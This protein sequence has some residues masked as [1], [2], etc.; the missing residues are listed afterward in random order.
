MSV[1]TF[2][3]IPWS[4][5]TD[6]L[7]SKPL[8]KILHQLIQ[9]IERIF[10]TVSTKT[11]KILS[12]IM[13]WSAE[14]IK[15]PFARNGRHLKLEISELITALV[16]FASSKNIKK[17][18]KI[19]EMIANKLLD[20]PKRNSIWYLRILTSIAIVVLQLNLNSVKKL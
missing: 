14:L 12:I 15:A 20:K 7:N 9:L 6:R 18:L 17:S 4:F 16:I 2:M 1:T 13:K 8:L 5:L 11:R 3:D 19:Q 10:N